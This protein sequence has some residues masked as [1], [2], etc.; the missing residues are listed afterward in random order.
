[1]DRNSN[2][3][4]DGNSDTA[5]TVSPTSKPATYVVLN[6][7][8]PSRIEWFRQ[9]SLHVAVVYHRLHSDPAGS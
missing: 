3:T 9:Q 6:L 1:M 4:G 7:L 5:S 2:T 8:P